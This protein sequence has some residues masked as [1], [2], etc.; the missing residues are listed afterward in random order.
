MRLALLLPLLLLACSNGVHGPPG[1]S[2][3]PGGNN[4]PGGTLPDGGSLCGANAGTSFPAVSTWYASSLSAAPITVTCK[5]GGLL[6]FPDGGAPFFLDQDGGF[7]SLAAGYDDGTLCPN[8]TAAFAPVAA[9][10]TRQD[11]S[12]SPGLI[13]RSGTFHT[14]APRSYSGTFTY[15]SDDRNCS[16]SLPEQWN[17]VPAPPDAG[18]D[19]G[20]VCKSTG[21]N[22]AP[23]M[24]NLDCVA[25]ACIADVCVNM[26][27]DEEAVDFSGT[28]CDLTECLADGGTFC[29]GAITNDPCLCA[30]SLGMPGT[31]TPIG[32][33]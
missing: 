13:T 16:I 7:L 4:G 1:G 21:T 30:S 31:T 27:C 22:D 26:Q 3:E 10:P 32:C 9:S 24:T 6:T 12:S 28:P 14:P 11:T 20:G 17:E 29:I 18:P 5:D 15:E 8:G 33:Q 23:C 2:R 19:A 25:A